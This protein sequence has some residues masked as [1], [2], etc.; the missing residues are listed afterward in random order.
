MSWNLYE[1]VQYTTSRPLL[2]LRANACTVHWFQCT[3]VVPLCKKNKVATCTCAVPLSIACD[4]VR[5]IWNVSNRPRS[6]CC[7]CI[8]WCRFFQFLRIWMV[9]TFR[10]ITIFVRI[11]WKCTQRTNLKALH[12]ISRHT[13]PHTTKC[14]FW[15]KTGWFKIWKSFLWYQYVN[16]NYM[17]PVF[18]TINIPRIV[19]RRESWS[20]SRE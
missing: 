11:L 4:C 19:Y 17:K 9:H 6:W 18:S 2:Q 8:F 15:W 5:A 7:V 10:E 13:Y 12:S 1:A 16:F 14:D 3:G 20:A